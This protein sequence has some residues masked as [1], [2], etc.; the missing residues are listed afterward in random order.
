MKR[1]KHR[2][3]HGFLAVALSFGAAGV[4]QAERQGF[5]AGVEVGVAQAQDLDSEVSGVSHPT[6]CDNLL[7]TG[8]TSPDAN[9]AACTSDT[10]SAIGENH[11]DLDTGFV[12]A[13]NAGYMMKRWRFEL[14]YLYRTHD[15][16]AS[17]WRGAGANAALVTKNP[18]WST[19]DPP[20]EQ[21]RDFRAHQFFVNAYYDFLGNPTWTPYVGV[22][23]GL[24]DTSLRYQMRFVRKA[25]PQYTQDNPSFHADVRANAA[26]TLSLL[27]T[28]L[29]ETLV[30]FQL[31]AGVDYAL[32]EKT[33]VG[34]KARWAQFEEL[35]DSDTWDVIRS[36]AP[37]Q[38][39]GQTPF[40]SRQ[41]FDDVEYWA[42]TIGIKHRF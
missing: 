19:V 12:G 21:V 31:L 8:G 33:S 29:D 42:L 36:H 28:E 40:T 4:A 2:C 26:G 34:L 6:R 37:V 14:E 25:N 10:P 17:P 39:D 15:G 24:A 20:S 23:V 35:E 22:G 7:Y 16:D 9:D 32:T 3:I 41:E 13:L 5:Y 27:D 1:S 38:A 18:E 11:F 30:G